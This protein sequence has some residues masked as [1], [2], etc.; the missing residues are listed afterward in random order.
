[1]LTANAEGVQFLDVVQVLLRTG[2]E[3]IDQFACAANCQIAEA[4]SRSIVAV[5]EPTEAGHHP[6]ESAFVALFAEIRIHTADRLLG[7]APIL[8]DD[9][10]ELLANGQRI[11]V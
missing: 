8:L 3:G 6:L 5:V 9:F 1:M 11:R 4:I 10:E 2:E 7:T